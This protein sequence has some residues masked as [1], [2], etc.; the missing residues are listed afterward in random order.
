MKLIRFDQGQ[1]PRLGILDGVRVHDIQSLFPALAAGDMAALL[2]LGAQARSTIAA[3][4]SKTPSVAAKDV[5]LL[6]PI[7]NPPKIICAWVNYPNPAVA[8]QPELPIFFSKYT[9]AIIGPYTPVQLPIIGDE[10]VVEPEL[11]AVIG[12][13]GR[14]IKAEDALKH[15][16]GYTIVNDVTAFSHRLQILLGSQGPYM[17]AK[18]F[19]TFA[20]MGPAIV[21]S[22]EVGDPHNLE[23]RQW[24][25]GELITAANTS[26]MIFKLPH[27]ISYVSGFFTLQPGDVLLTGSPPPNSGKPYFL[28]AGDKFRIEI[29]KVGILD[30][31]AIAE[32]DAR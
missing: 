11:S 16:A 3:Q 23:V 4:Q 24:T 29:S 8:K 30:S 7:A 14:H 20:P 10:I 28:K 19:D 9:S 32:A 21:T 12:I 18:S 1:G 17:M 25:N 22:D 31:T 13:G 26:E 6:A 15:V 2:A 27:L 5:R